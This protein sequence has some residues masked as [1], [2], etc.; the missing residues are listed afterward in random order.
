M[1]ARERFDGAREIY[2]LG[3]DYRN[4]RKRQG[5]LIRVFQNRQWL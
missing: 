5:Q 1:G 3:Q 4:R 2:L